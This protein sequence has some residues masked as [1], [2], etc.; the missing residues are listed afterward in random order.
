LK[1]HIVRLAQSDLF[2]S[3]RAFVDPGSAPAPESMP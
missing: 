3:A 1:N 2:R